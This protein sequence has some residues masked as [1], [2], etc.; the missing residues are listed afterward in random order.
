MPRQNRFPSSTGIYHIIL[1]GNNKN[2]IFLCEKDMIKFLEI[3][4]KKRQN[5][6]YLIF[7]Y[8]LMRNHVHLILKEENET[9]PGIMKKINVSYAIYFNKKYD[10]IGHVF[11]DRYKSINVEDE[12]YLI[13]LVRYIHNNPVE[14]GIV[15]KPWHY[16]WSSMKSYINKDFT[17]ING[18]E[19]LSLF[20][21]KLNDAIKQLKNFTIDLEDKGDFLNLLD[22][23]AR[24][25]EGKKIVEKYLNERQ[26]R[27]C[28]IQTDKEIRNNLIELLKNKYGLSIRKISEILNI[29]RNMVQR[30]K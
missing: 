15:K 14:A 9:L 20:S 29:N 3:L 26:K 24:I 21:E 12:G 7:A 10:R 4:K 17:L 23:Q 8:C 13:R 1:R 28:D 19:I 22:S 27:F 2:D 16:N 30:V 6:E 18:D 11:Q 25:N 5:R